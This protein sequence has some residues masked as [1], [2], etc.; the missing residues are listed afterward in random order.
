MEQSFPTVLKSMSEAGLLSKS[1]A[2]TLIFSLRLSHQDKVREGSPGL[3]LLRQMSTALQLG[4]RVIP[5]PLEPRAWETHPLT[6]VR[7]SNN[8]V[9]QQKA[10]EDRASA[11]R[12]IC[13]CQAS[14]KK[15]I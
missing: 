10:L 1:S 15:G 8:S 5:V 11:F 12:I 4:H 14:L 7:K 2:H 9:A 6:S 3:S 13:N